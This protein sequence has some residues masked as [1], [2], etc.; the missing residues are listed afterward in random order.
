VTTP[1]EKVVVLELKND[2]VQDEG[3]RG[4]DGLALI[5][6]PKRAWEERECRFGALETIEISNMKCS[7]L[8]KII[9]CPFLHELI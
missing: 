1:I 4:G 5:I 8:Q 3:R 7:I 6:T 9:L 2:I